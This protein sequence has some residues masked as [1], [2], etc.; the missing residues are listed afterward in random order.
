MDLTAILNAMEQKAEA[1]Y[2]ANPDYHGEGKRGWHV[3]EVKNGRREGEW[4]SASRPFGAVYHEPQTEAEFT[5]NAGWSYEATVRGKIA[6]ARRTGKNSGTNFWEVLGGESF[7]KG[8]VFSKD[9]KCI[10]GFS[11]LKGHHDVEISQAGI[12]E[13]ERQADA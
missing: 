9:G 2:K 6:Y 1:I 11:G 3:V 8:A 12:A 4:D 13:Y 5:I 7:W 10:C